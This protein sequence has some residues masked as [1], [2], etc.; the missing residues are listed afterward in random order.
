MPDLYFRIVRGSGLSPQAFEERLRDDRRIE[1]LLDSVKAQAKVTDEDV[2]TAYAKQ[3]ERLRATMVL[4]A[5]TT[6]EPQ[7]KPGLTEDVLRHYYMTHQEAVQLPVTRAFEYIGMSLREA[8]DHIGA[9]SAEEIDAY[10]DDHPDQFTQAD[11]SVK[12]LTDVR[13]TIEQDRKTEKARKRL[14]DL[15]MDLEEDLD[16]GVRFV[17]I[18]LTRGLFA[19]KTGP[20]ERTAPSLPNGPTNSMVSEAFNIPVGKMTQVFDTA[21]GVFLLLPLNETP[22]RIPPFEAVRE[23]VKALIVQE[24]AREAA[25]TRLGELHDAL[26]A[27]RKDGFTIEEAYRLL[28]IQP[29]RPAPFTREDPIE[30][31]GHVPTVSETFFT[32]KPGEC[33]QALETP[34]GFLV[35]CLEERL[36][37]DEGQFANDKDAFRK[38]LLDSTQQTQLD[39]WIQSLRTR[40]DLKSFLDQPP[41]PQ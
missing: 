31:V 32:L 16:N 39:T 27:K 4:I 6:F 10:Y 26:L 37:Y 28:K 36:P 18:A 41:S 35:G 7:I 1:K 14:T 12:P 25:K 13:D 40:A 24:R 21:L 5:P 11:G 30:P 33:S 34:Q 19:H 2:K 20:L 29:L 15:A 38:T 9:V 8:S 23:H 22:A 17:E 3:H